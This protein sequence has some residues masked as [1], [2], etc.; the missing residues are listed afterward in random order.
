MSVTITTTDFKSYFDRGQFTFGTVLPAVRDKDI[1]AAIAEATAVINLSL[2]P[3]D[4]IAIM[5]LEYLT[6]HFLQLDIEAANASGQ[7]VFNQ[8]SRSADGISESLQI[9]E[10]MTQGEYALY[11]TTYYGQKY[12]TI[13]KPYLDGAVYAVEGATMP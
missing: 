5:A 11:S 13:S 12:I 7:P 4:A 3:T 1:T 9:P 2:Y 6:A 8:A 10:W